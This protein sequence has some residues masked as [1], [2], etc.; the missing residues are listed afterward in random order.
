MSRLDPDHSSSNQSASEDQ[1]KLIGQLREQIA[2]LSVQNAQSRP[3]SGSSQDNS[4]IKEVKFLPKNTGKF[5]PLFQ[6]ESALATIQKEKEEL[7]N[8]ITSLESKLVLLTSEVGQ[9]DEG[10]L[11]SRTQI[12]K[13]REDIN[14]KDQELQRRVFINT[15][16]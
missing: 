11:Q 13:L 4:K 10:L 5:H 16:L 8:Q 9:R 2:T 12:D 14:Q 15:Q 7:S 6:L 1:S 3:D